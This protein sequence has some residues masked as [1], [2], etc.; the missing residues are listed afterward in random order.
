MRGSTI[1][2]RPSH[3]RISD[4]PYAH[5]GYSSVPDWV[6]HYAQFGY[7]ESSDS[8]VSSRW[9]VSHIDR[10]RSSVYLSG[11]ANTFASDRSGKPGNTSSDA[12]RMASRVASTTP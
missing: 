11:W 2:F 12:S 5:L 1:L 8:S 3:K 6:Q 7:R 4:G 9:T 10:P